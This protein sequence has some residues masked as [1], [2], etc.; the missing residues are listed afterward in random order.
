[1]RSFL[2]EP[3]VHFLLL[4]AMLL[5][6]DAV[7]SRYRK[8]VVTITPAALKAQAEVAAQRL[9]RPLTTQ[10]RDKLAREMLQEEILFREAQQRGLMDDNRVRGTLVAMMRSALKPVA[11]PATEEE[12]KALSA[13]LPRE[14]SILP[15]QISFDHVSFPSSTEILPDILDKLK[16]GADPKSFGESVRLA[17]PLPPT[18]RPQV[19][20][21]FGVPFAE[22]V[23][24]APLNEWCGP[25]RSMRGVHFV[26]VTSRQ[27]EQPLPLEQLRPVLEFHRMQ[28]QEA[29]TVG[30]EVDKLKANYRLV[31]PDLSSPEEAAK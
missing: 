7:C 10:E 5:G 1:M 21:L 24:K 27:A 19:E 28:R 26:R 14:T 4:G 31:M 18:Y 15:E 29:E 2:R 3:L 11:A 9:G 23:F 17:N 13:Q 8:P 30:R 16:H 20:H 25:I 12:L 22:E 6:L